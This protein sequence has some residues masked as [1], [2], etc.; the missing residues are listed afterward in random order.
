MVRRL[1]KPSS[2][3]AALKLCVGSGCIAA[4]GAVERCLACEADG[5][6]R[7]PVSHF[8]PLSTLNI[9]DVDFDK[10]TAKKIRARSR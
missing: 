1:Q 2:G 8:I 5:E 10:G 6:R 3:L 7:D 4:V 9:A